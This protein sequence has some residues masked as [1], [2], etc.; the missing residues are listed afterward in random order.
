MPMEVLQLKILLVEDN[1]GDVRLLKELCKDAK[2]LDVRFEEAS[3]LAEALDLISQSK[4][5][6]IIMDLGLPDSQGLSTLNAMFPHTE[7]TPIIVLTGLDDETTAFN[8]V[9]NGAQDY[10]TKEDISPQLINKSIRY[11]I[12]RNQSK[13]IL[14]ESWR[15]LDTLLGN[16]P[17]MAYRIRYDDH[18]TVEFISAG[19]MELTGY[20]VQELQNN[21]ALALEDL[22]LKNDRPSIK[23]LLNKTRRSHQQ[24]QLNY[25]LKTRQGQIKWMWEQG[26][27]IYAE[28]NSDAIAREGFITD[29]THRKKT[30]QAL[31]ESEHFAHSTLNALSSN[32]AILDKNGVIINV[33]KAWKKFAEQNNSKNVFIG[34]NYLAITDRAAAQGDRYALKAAKGLKSVMNRK[35]NEFTLEYP[36]HSPSKKRWFTLRATPFL[37]TGGAE[38]VI[39]HTEITAR[40][41]A[42]ESLHK[43]EQRYR[44]LAE[45]SI[46]CIW[47]MDLSLK[48]TYA[49]PSIYDLT[50][51]T[52]DEFVG[53]RLYQHCSRKEFLKM[54]RVAVKVM[55]NF[56]TKEKA[57]IIAFIKRK[58]GTEIPVEIN[59]RVILNDKGKP[60]AYQGTTRNISARLQSQRALQESEER[61]RGVYENAAVGLYRTTPDGQI[62]MANPALVKL[63]EYDSEQDLKKRNLEKEGFDSIERRRQFKSILQEKGTINSVEAVWKTKYGK[64]IHILESARAVQDEEGN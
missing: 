13:K 59:G 22:I 63:L 45:N 24:Y 39:A 19:C 6:L 20:S 25:R 53:T 27:W 30:E 29:I 1:P 11:A 23:S 38:I 51:Y 12:Q 21:S 14:K 26:T 35:Q 42:E 10:L 56:K 52:Q 64:M 34:D 47:Q 41:L 3:L 17:G 49:S 8:A 16:L 58:D 57:S 44:L 33:N 48:F 37:E 50:G 40:K 28:N 46:D 7:D 31:R 32:I 18:E 5:D 15:S 43:S 54:A 62:E 36:C 61:F 2:N 55:K 60:T 9:K 4:Y